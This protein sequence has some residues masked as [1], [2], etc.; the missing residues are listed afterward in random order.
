MSLQT[1]N[2]KVRNA[3]L[4]STLLLVAN[5]LGCSPSN[6]GGAPAAESIAAKG[7]ERGNGAEFLRIE[8]GSAWFVDDSRAIKSCYLLSPSFGIPMNQV[9]DAIHHG[10]K[11]WG[12][13]IGSRVNAVKPGDVFNLSTTYSLSNACVGDEDLVFYLGVSTPEI[14]NELNQADASV[15]VAVRTGYSV[16]QRW[17]KGFIWFAAQKSVSA[18]DAKDSP[19]LIPDWN[20]AHSLEAMVLHE[21]GHVYG[22][23][24]ANGTVMSESIVRIIQKNGPEPERRFLLDI[25]HDLMLVD[26]RQKLF[27]GRLGL[28]TDATAHDGTVIK[29][30]NL[31]SNFELL[32]GRKPVGVVSVSFDF[33]S[34]GRAT[35]C[36]VFSFGHLIIEDQREKVEKEICSLDG[37]R[38]TN[39]LEPRFKRV[40]ERSFGTELGIQ[41]AYQS[42]GGWSAAGVI[43]TA[44]GESLNVMVDGNQFVQMS[45]GRLSPH[46]FPFG[47]KLGIRI[48]LKDRVEPLFTMISD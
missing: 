3:T 9:E 40:V 38:L 10:F 11:T 46:F 30:D 36:A 42:Y 44:A 7:H 14:A 15:A 8:N 45:W 26:S 39:P 12:S 29:E 34:L 20:L 47:G 23:G 41:E 43:Q 18:G 6:S 28:K 17:G 48:F 5:L 21:L 37:A 27:K 35:N 16:K 4:V 32:V 24:H 31:E 1:T 19:T 25:D 13:Y 2:H 22:N 33:E